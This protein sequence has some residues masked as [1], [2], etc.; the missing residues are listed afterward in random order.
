MHLNPRIMKQSSVDGLTFVCL[1]LTNTGKEEGM[2]LSLVAVPF[3]S[4]PSP[5]GP[6]CDAIAIGMDRSSHVCAPPTTRI[7]KKKKKAKDNS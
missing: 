4:F 6:F 7:M 5:R 3:Q 1:M 2:T